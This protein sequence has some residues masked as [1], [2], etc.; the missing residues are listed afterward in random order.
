MKSI[1]LKMLRDLKTLRGQAIA[2][3]LVIIAGVSVYVSMM[4]VAD[5]LKQTLDSYYKRYV[6]ADGFASLRRAP[7]SVAD[8]LREIPGISRVE[9]RVLAGVTVDMPDYTEPVSG[10]ILSIPEGRQPVLN[11][12]FI[13]QGRLTAPGREDEVILNEIFAEAH[14][15]KPGDNLTVIINGRYRTLNIVG[16]ALSPEFIYQAQPGSLFP[17]PKGFG[18]M[19]MGRRALASVYGMEGA[20]NNVS[21]TLA[22]GYRTE[23]I[24]SRMDILLK[25]YGSQGA[26]SRE[27]QFSHVMISEELNQL[28]TMAFMLPVIFLA[29]AAFLLNIVVSRLIALQ[30]EQIAVLKALGYGN[31]TVAI[32]YLKMVLVIAMTGAAGGTALGVYMGGAIAEL[33]LDYFDFPFL[34]YSLDWTVVLT[35]VVLTGGASLGGALLSV[36]HALKMPPAEAMRPATPAV[37]KPTTIERI[38][39]QHLFDQPTRIILRNLERKWIKSAL[40]VVGISSA[41]AILV[42]GL[43]WGDVIGYIINVQYNIAQR[44]DLT[45]TFIEP[46]S[47]ST[48]HEL[49]G[50]QGVRYAEPF[51]IVPVRLRKEHRSYDTGLEGITDEPYLRRIIDKDLRPIPI[52]RDG[53]VLTQNLANILRV[54]PGDKITVEVMEGRRYVRDVPVVGIA[55][56]YL[57]SGAYMSMQAVNRLVGDG[58]AISGAFLMIDERYENDLI[59]QLGD[60][61]RVASIMSSKKAIQAYMDSAADL[62]LGFAFILSIFAGIIALGVVYNSMRI[63]LSERDRELA[64]LRV[65]GFTRGEISYILLGEMALL[66]LCSIPVG[67]LIGYFF[68]KISTEALETD[69]YSFPLVMESGTFALAATIIIIAAFLSALL[70]RTRINKL[71]MIAVLKTRE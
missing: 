36:K 13:R 18:V 12:L 48:V 64:S 66:V 27:D 26:Y 24:I 5:T 20:F 38:G 21:F 15:L 59:R 44:D 41:C 65:L 31:A 49:T 55:E 57:G 3:I 4:S 6:F 51:R 58:N 33:Y 43:F 17:D 28:A 30:R 69:M 35:A 2:I 46:T 37:Y 32:H 63:S 56:Q 29:V 61:P 52:P 50:L 54:T 62:L 60:R 1:D 68:S 71:D 40:T 7:E 11:R 16:V 70:M 22:P 9:T 25:P 53:I 39:I 34:E 23:N 67:F 42:M 47:A 19:W 45:V 10:Q 8:R 14:D